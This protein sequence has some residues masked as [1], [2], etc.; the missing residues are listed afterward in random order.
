VRRRE[1]AVSRLHHPEVGDLDPYRDKLAVAGTSDQLV[2]VY[3]AEPGSESARS[4][5]LLGSLAAT[6]TTTGR[7]T[8]TGR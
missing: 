3:H 8:P 2:V 6:D 7:R 4:L 5:A 1:S